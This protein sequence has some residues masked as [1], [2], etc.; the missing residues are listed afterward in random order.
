MLNR[1]NFIANL[2][3]LLLIQRSGDTARVLARSKLFTFLFWA[4][5]APCQPVASAK[6]GAGL[7]VHTP[8]GLSHRPAPGPS[9]E[10]ALSLSKGRYPL[11][12]LTQAWRKHHLTPVM[13]N[14]FRHP[15]IQSRYTNTNELMTNEPNRGEIVRNLKNIF[16]F[17][18]HKK[19]SALC[20]K[21]SAQTGENCKKFKER[22]YF[23][24]HKKLSALCFK[25]SAQTG[26]NCKKF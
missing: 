15:I 7:S 26:G 18:P 1:S 4:Y 17:S 23:S 10:P 6:A 14:S 2:L 3:F 19:L 12:S 22:F 11:L 20:F 24:P 13:P 8:A 25:L 5:P 16:Y 9:Q 21:L